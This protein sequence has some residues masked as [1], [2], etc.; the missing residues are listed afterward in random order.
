MQTQLIVRTV[1]P[2]LSECVFAAGKELLNRYAYSRSD[3]NV[4]S[5]GQ[6]LKVSGIMSAMKYC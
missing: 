2:R 1:S 6:N 5:E 3:E 4:A